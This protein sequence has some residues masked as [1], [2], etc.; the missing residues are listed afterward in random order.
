MVEL[1]AQTGGAQMRDTRGEG[2]G[3]PKLRSLLLAPRLAGDD[4]DRQVLTG[5]PVVQ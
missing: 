3:R 1:P 5:H 2:S 4:T